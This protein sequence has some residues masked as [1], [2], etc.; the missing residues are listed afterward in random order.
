MYYEISVKHNYFND[1]QEV[2]TQTSKILVNNV[3]EFPE[4]WNK[5]MKYAEQEWTADNFDMAPDVT[6]MKRSRIYEFA[7]KETDGEKIYLATLDDVFVDD[8]GKEK[9]TKYPVGVYAD[10]ITAAKKN[11]D[12]YMLQM[13]DFTLTDLN[14]TKFEHVVE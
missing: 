11:I 3:R 4:A 5:A 10:D 12:S 14:E 13:Q 2:K 8:S 6:A 9:H 1:N 7:N